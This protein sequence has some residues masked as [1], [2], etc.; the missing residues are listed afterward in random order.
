MCEKYRQSCVCEREE[1]TK[2]NRKNVN[3]DILLSSIERGA[4]RF[5]NKL[6]RAFMNLSIFHFHCINLNFL[7]HSLTHSLSRRLFFD[8]F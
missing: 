4:Y 7:S 8:T 6:E 5:H 1:K 3:D 2:T